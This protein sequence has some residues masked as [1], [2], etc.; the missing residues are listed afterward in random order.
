MSTQQE[1]QERAEKYV[2]QYFSDAGCV[3]ALKCAEDFLAGEISGHQRAMDEMSA[4]SAEGFEEFIKGTWVNYIAEKDGVTCCEHTW[5]LGR[6]PLL[7]R[8]EASKQ[9]VQANVLVPNEEY[10]SQQERITDLEA[11]NKKLGD[12]LL[13]MVEV[14]D[15]IKDDTDSFVIHGDA[16]D[17]LD[18]H[19]ELIAKL[20]E[21]LK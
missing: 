21:E 3:D 10:Q 19:A 14:L 1:A 16:K 18:K 13:E 8:I 9:D 4:K 20:R 11:Q 6:A 7:A 2:A 15:R 17:A 12:A 5:Q